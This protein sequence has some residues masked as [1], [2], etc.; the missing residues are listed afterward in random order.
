MGPQ[1]W[2]W[3]LVFK[4]LNTRSNS[5]TLNILN[6]PSSSNSNRV[7]LQFLRVCGRESL[8]RLSGGW[9]SPGPRRPASQLCWRCRIIEELHLAA[10]SC[11]AVQTFITF[12]FVAHGDICHPASQVSFKGRRTYSIFKWGLC[13]ARRRKCKQ[14]PR[15]TFQRFLRLAFRYRPRFPD[16]LTKPIL[17]GEVHYLPDKTNRE[18]K[19][20]ESVTWAVQ[21][22]FM[23]SCL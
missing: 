9:L 23:T 14:L 6:D 17:L 2:Q 19:A 22:C 5:N 8:F 15:Y 21:A 10:W 12:V 1:I 16:L 11:F 20:H 13:S 7:R 4:Q 3:K 18:T